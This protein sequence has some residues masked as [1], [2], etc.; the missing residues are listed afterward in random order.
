MIENKKQTMAGTVP[1]TEADLIWN[2]LLG[3][4]G[5]ALSQSSNAQQQQPAAVVPVEQ[6]PPE[7]APTTYKADAIANIISETYSMPGVPET[8]K[9]RC[10]K[11]RIAERFGEDEAKKYLRTARKKVP[12]QPTPEVAP[13]QT[14]VPTPTPTQPPAQVPVASPTPAEPSIISID[15]TL[16]KLLGPVQQDEPV[17]TPAPQ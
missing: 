4:M 9:R 17:M 12:A 7:P 3:R 2:M 16:R 6:S 15:G 8:T 10:A 1:S 11:R 14:P 13:T 5:A